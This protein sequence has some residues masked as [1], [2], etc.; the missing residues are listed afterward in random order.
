MDKSVRKAQ[1]GGGH[2]IGDKRLQTFPYKTEL[3]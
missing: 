1:G 3:S 2:N